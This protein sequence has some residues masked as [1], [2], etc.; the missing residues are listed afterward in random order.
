ML[1]SWAVPVYKITIDVKPMPEP[2]WKTLVTACAGK[3]DSL[4]ELLQGKFSK[5]VME[6]ILKK[7]EDY[8]Q[9]LRRLR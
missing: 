6:I 1:R 7:R 9:S 2:K 4:I 3:I 5:A 8:F